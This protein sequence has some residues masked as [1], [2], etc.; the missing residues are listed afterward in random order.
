MD[1]K[2]FS[3]TDLKDLKDSYAACG[4]ATVD[5]ALTIPTRPCQIDERVAG[6]RKRSSTEKA[7]PFQWNS[8]AF[9]MESRCLS[10]GKPTRFH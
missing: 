8:V 4:Y 2:E 10:N 1:W 9:S 6:K 7:L 5:R 3:H